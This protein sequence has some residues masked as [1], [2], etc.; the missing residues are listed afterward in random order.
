MIPVA[1]GERIPW[2]ATPKRVRQAV[3]AFL[4]ERVVQA[5][6]QPLGFSPAVAARLVT[7]SGKRVFVKAVPPDLNPD[8]P[9]IYRRE[10]KVCQA[11]PSDVPVPRFEW[12]LDEGAEGWVVLVFEH[13]DA[14]P[15]QLPWNDAE[16]RLAVHAIDELAVKLT[17]S[18]IREGQQGERMARAWARWTQLA[19]SPPPELEPWFHDRWEELIELDSRLPELTAGDTLVHLDIRSDNLLIGGG[20]CWVVDWAWPLLGAAWMDIVLFSVFVEGEGGPSAEKVLS[21]SVAGRAA[22]PEG[23]LALLATIA[24]GLTFQSCQ[25]PPP[26]L[27]GLR[28]FQAAHARAAR[29]WLQRMRPS[30]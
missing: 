9:E 4:G 30:R 19:A 23:V 22:P 1:R 28:P 21:L 17:P 14:A 18:P 5:T 29:A 20:R 2:E 15:P 3:E 12:S 16:L 27:P 25:P 13:I 7:A 26:G 6:T 11:L 10:I 8:T 24:G